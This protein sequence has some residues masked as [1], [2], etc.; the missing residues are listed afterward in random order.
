MNLQLLLAR[1]DELKAA[2]GLSDQALS[3][4]AGASKDLIRNWRRA[5]RSDKH[6]SANFEKLGDVA[7]VLGVSV[8]ALVEPSLN[9]SEARIA[10]LAM[11][12]P[13]HLHQ[14]A[15]GYLEGLLESSDPAQP[16]SSEA[17]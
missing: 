3:E 8:S 6:S 4:R 5:V 10:Q 15:I 12:L 17:G 2:Q 14:R 16:K 9:P 7:R 13:E 11:Q 1:I